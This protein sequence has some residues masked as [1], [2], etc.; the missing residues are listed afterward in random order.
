MKESMTILAALIL[1]LL[2]FYGCAG[3]QQQPKEE[4]PIGKTAPSV[5][6]SSENLMKNQTKSSLADEISKEE[7]ELLDEFIKESQM[8]EN[9]LDELPTEIPLFEKSS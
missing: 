1:S 8:P 9:D 6:T 7:M 4:E 3:Q 2:L 5:S